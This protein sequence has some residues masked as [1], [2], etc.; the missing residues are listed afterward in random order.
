M[1]VEV[2][3]ID[4]LRVAALS[5]VGP[6]R[7]LGEAFAQLSRIA[8]AAGLFRPGVFM[9]GIFYDDPRTTPEVELRSD[10]VIL[11]GEDTAIPE[12]LAEARIAGGRY[13]TT[14]HMGPYRGLADT[15]GRFMGEWLPESGHEIGAGPSYEVYRNDPSR[16]PEHQI[17]TD[18]YTPLA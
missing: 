14:T 18:L 12:G 4:G 3:E 15:W 10:A 8:A 11:I 17:R 16:V 9:L 6:Y 7:G 13:A 5:H 2:R 1:E